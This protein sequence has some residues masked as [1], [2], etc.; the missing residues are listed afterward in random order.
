[1]RRFAEVATWGIQFRRTAS[2]QTKVARLVGLLAFTGSAQL[3]M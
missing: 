3:L 1:M 2:K